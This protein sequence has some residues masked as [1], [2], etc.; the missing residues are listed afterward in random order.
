MECT[1][2]PRQKLIKNVLKTALKLSQTVD[3]AV[4][5]TVTKKIGCL[6]WCNKWPKEE[7]FVYC[8]CLIFYNIL[9]V[10]Y[11]FLQVRLKAADFFCIFGLKNFKLFKYHTEFYTFFSCYK[12]FI[13]YYY[14]VV[15]VFVFRKTLK[16]FCFKTKYQSTTVFFKAICCSCVCCVCH[17]CRVCRFAFTPTFNTTQD[18]TSIKSESKHLI[19]SVWLFGRLVTLLRVSMK[20]VFVSVSVSVSS[21]IDFKKS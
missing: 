7:L 11:I 10:I 12:A 16:I 2:K 6:N 17:V 5:A 20:F 3:A 4:W 21:I 1:R 13:C 14:F 15:A 18:N 9:N 8:C 19:Y